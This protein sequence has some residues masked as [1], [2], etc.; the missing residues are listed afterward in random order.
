MLKENNVADVDLEFQDA[1]L[2]SVETA[3]LLLR[4]VQFALLLLTFKWPKVANLVYASDLACMAIWTLV[5][6]YDHSQVVDLVYYYL[7]IQNFLFSTFQPRCDIAVNCAFIVCFMNNQIMTFNDVTVGQ[8]LYMNI[9]RAIISIVSILIYHKSLDVFVSLLSERDLIKSSH[10]RFVQSL[11]EG[12]VIVD[13]LLKN[14]K[15]IN[16]AACQMLQMQSLSDSSELPNFDQIQFKRIELGGE[17]SPRL[18]NIGSNV[19]RSVVHI[20]LKDVIEQNLKDREFAAW[21]EVIYELEFKTAAA[22]QADD[23]VS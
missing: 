16:V 22:S 18:V 9:P 4:A 15:L 23:D 5:P 8:V 1:V 17:T 20:P 6:C 7:L 21:D 14:I 10:L 3:Y 13:D 11:R 19:Y 12:F 2:E